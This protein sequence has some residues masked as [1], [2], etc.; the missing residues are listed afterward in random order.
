[1]G[2]IW[3]RLFI[4]DSSDKGGGV[5]L[6]SQLVTRGIYNEGSGGWGG[7]GQIWEAHC[8]IPGAW[9]SMKSSP[10]E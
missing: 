5:N 10:D 4:T 1:M 3:L 2:H 6:E 9:R 7:S 8:H